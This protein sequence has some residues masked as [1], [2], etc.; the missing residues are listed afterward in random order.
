[1]TKKFGW[2]AIMYE[3]CNDDP[4]KLAEVCKLPLYETLQMLTFKTLLAEETRHKQELER[5][6][7]AAKSGLRR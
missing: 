7:N 2:S 5:A 4:T 1:M 6:L 3:L